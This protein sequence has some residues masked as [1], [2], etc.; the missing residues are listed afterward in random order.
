MLFHALFKARYHELR[1]ALARRMGDAS[2]AAESAHEAYLRLAAV[3]RARIGD[4]FAYAVTVAA[5][6]AT[7]QGRRQHLEQRLFAPDPDLDQHPDAAPWPE[8]VAAA[9]QEVAFLR[10]ALAELPPKPRTALLLSRVEGWS[11]ARIA[12]H[13][14]VSERMVAKHIA[15]GLHHL[16]RRLRDGHA[17]EG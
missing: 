6:L 15:S 12:R 7:D 5:N 4:P 13:L 17:H 10:V 1:A 2:L 14:Q 16:R 8:R 9:R 3:E 11:H